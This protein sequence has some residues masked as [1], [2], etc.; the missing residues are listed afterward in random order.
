MRAVNPLAKHFGDELDMLEVKAANKRQAALRRQTRDLA[1][2]LDG[3]DA[4][5]L[6]QLPWM[7]KARTEPVPLKVVKTPMSAEPELDDAERAR[8]E[9]LS[10]QALEA[11]EARPAYES[12]KY[13]RS[14]L[15]RYEFLFD[16]AESRGVVLTVED[17]AWKAYYEQSAEY[18]D[19]TGRRFEQLR[20]A[21]ATRAQGGPL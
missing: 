14:E 10:R 17:A 5:G 13:F 1:R 18:R 7:P 19:L 4:E 11:A 2:E 9:A 20:K 6:E 21:Y 12:P 16:L 8:L 3:D 15:E